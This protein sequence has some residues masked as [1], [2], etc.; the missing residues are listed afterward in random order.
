MRRA[1]AL[2]WSLLLAPVALALAATREVRGDAAAAATVPLPLTCPA[3]TVLVPE[4]TA[5]LGAA[6]DDDALAPITRVMKPYC[7]DRTEVTVAQYRACVAQGACASPETTV[8]FPGYGPPEPMK[9]ELSRYCN[10]PREDRS[11]HPMNCVDEASAARYCAWEGGR[12]P[13]EEEWEYAARGPSSPRF[14]WG[15]AVPSAPG[16]ALC[17]DRRATAQGTCAVGQFPDGASFA[18]AVDMAGN[19]WEWTSSR[20]T[21]GSVVRGGGWTNFLPRLV[22]ATYRW[23][24][25]PTTRLNCVGFRCVRASR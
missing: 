8:S 21:E 9:T 12:L 22:S 5:T 25:F 10:A 3:G 1:S 17:W 24:L 6:G 11:E 7:I 18:G 23:P 14:P 13:T 4:G 2:P 19:V 15:A 16:G 20:T